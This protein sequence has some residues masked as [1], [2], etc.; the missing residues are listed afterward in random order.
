VF[1]ADLLHL[2][3]EVTHTGV[4]IRSTEDNKAIVRRYI[5]ELDKGNVAVIDE[6]LSPNFVDHNPDPDQI[7]AYESW[8]QFTTES[9]RAFSNSHTTIHHLIAEGDT[10]VMHVT[11]SGTHTGEFLGKPATGKQIT[12]TYI[13]ILRIADGKIV[14]SWDDMGLQKDFEQ[15]F[16]SE[17][18]Q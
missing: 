12:V 11:N 5:E 16:L 14:E 15:I 8:K 10:I 4:C 13:R 9:V 2:S 6:L 1:R 7:S 3:K 17:S 18:A